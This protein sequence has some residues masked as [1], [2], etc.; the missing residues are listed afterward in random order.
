MSKY[1]SSISYLVNSSKSHT[2]ITFLIYHLQ[3][4]VKLYQ[5]ILNQIFGSLLFTANDFCQEVNPR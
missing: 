3:V 1:I 2:I 5:V 4:A